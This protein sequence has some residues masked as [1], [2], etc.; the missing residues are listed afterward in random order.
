M[1]V[2]RVGGTPKEVVMKGLL[3]I[4]SYVVISGAF[5]VLI[6]IGIAVS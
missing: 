6:V 1:A 4:P 2:T 5:A 3:K